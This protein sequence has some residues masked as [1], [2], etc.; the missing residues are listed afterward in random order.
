MENENNPNMSFASSAEIGARISALRKKRRL[1]QAYLAN[2]LGKSLRTI[3]KY[4]SGEIELSVSIAN[5]LAVILGTTPEFI[6]GYDSS[7]KTINTLADITAFLFQLEQVA[8]LELKIHAERPQDEFRWYC[9]IWFDGYRR[10]AE[11]NEKMCLFLESWAHQRQL[12]LGGWSNPKKY[13]QWKTQIL[14]QQEK[15]PVLC[16]PS[17]HIDEYVIDTGSPTPPSE[18][19]KE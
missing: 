14:A 9:S 18:E 6:L 4:E 13:E 17:L 3:Q 5:R 8:N 7:T 12:L 19:S 2:R 11:L 10:D 16:F 15:I 1:T